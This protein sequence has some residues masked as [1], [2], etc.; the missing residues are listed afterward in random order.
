MSMH[1]STTDVS[2]ML[3]KTTLSQLRLRDTNDHDRELNPEQHRVLR[4]LWEM[5]LDRPAIDRMLSLFHPNRERTALVSFDASGENSISTLVGLEKP[6]TDQGAVAGVK[7]VPVVSSDTDHDSEDDG[8]DAWALGMEKKEVAVALPHWNGISDSKEVPMAV[9]WLFYMYRPMHRPPQWSHTKANSILRSFGR[10]ACVLY[11]EGDSLND[12]KALLV[13]R[14]TTNMKMIHYYNQDAAYAIVEGAYGPMSRLALK[15]GKLPPNIAT[16]AYV[17]IYN[18]ATGNSTLVWILNLIGLALDSKLQP[19]AQWLATKRRNINHPIGLLH[20]PGGF[21]N[22]QERPQTYTDELTIALKAFYVKVMLK[23]FAAAV[24]L[25][26]KRLVI[27]FMGTSADKDI[28]VLDEDRF[29]SYV[30]VGAIQDAATQMKFHSVP[31]E[32]AFG[33]VT[34]GTPWGV[35]MIL[36]SYGPADSPMAQWM[37]TIGDR[38]PDCLENDSDELL[39]GTVMCNE[40]DPWSVAGNGNKEDDTLN[41]HIGRASAIAILTNPATNP[42][43]L[44]ADPVMVKGYR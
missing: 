6:Y 2:N 27:P 12:V 3:P 1:V 5:E 24:K 36:T 18:A 15:S 10:D 32:P 43:I 40:C 22:R 13:G 39:R 33:A 25:K 44:A 28:I 11:N 42:Y 9:D 35:N 20:E 23:A 31:V 7:C 26:A 16:M 41:G 21:G 4:N 29:T 19:D 8:D 34:L 30:I 17:P 38:F 37:G 14:E